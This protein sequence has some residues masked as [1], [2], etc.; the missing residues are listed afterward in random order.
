[1][2]LKNFSESSPEQCR[3]NWNTGQVLIQVS[4]PFQFRA[5]IKS[6]FTLSSLNPSLGQDLASLKRRLD[7]RSASVG[8]AEICPENAKKAV[9]LSKIS[10]ETEKKLA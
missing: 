8:K 5:I 6:L 10:L 7:I 2:A 3:V 9:K 4:F 1:M